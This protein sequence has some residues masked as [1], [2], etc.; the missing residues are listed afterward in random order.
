MND[1]SKF[2]VF[3]AEPIDNSADTYEIFKESGAELIVGPPVSCP[4][5]G[6]SEDQLVEMCQD[7]DAFFGMARERV[8]RKVI[9]ASPKLRVI[10][11]YGNGTD[12]IDV[13]AATEQ[14][15]LVCNA[16]VH[17]NTVAEYTFSLILGLLKK[18]PYDVEHL[19][20]GGWR[21][22]STVGNELYHKTVGIV[23]FGA[24]GKQ[25]AKRLK[26]WETRVMVCDPLAT[27]ENAELLGAEL[28]DWDTLFRSADVVTIHMPLM[29]STRGIVGAKEFKMMK[30]RAIFINAARGPIVDEAAL[31]EALQNK[32][33]GGAALDVFLKEPVT[34]DHPLLHM[35]NVIMTPHTAGFTY[36]SMLRIAGQATQNCISAL[37]GEKPEFVVNPAALP[38]WRE[39]FVQE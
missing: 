30:N 11:K 13:Q 14:G 23:G 31:I 29:D 24:I 25:L 19:R 22:S 20:A 32:E 5:Q 34:A 36:E 35:K 33:I 7:V 18:L 9:S 8:T 17:N 2:K 6:Y 26:G 38:K 28:V 3:I 27:R 39:R 1:F 10:C 16:P 15:V 12:N 4:K 37:N 21:D